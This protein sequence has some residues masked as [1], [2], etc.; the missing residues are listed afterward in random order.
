MIIAF[1]TIGFC[2]TISCYEIEFEENMFSV[3]NYVFV[4]G[5]ADV[6]ENINSDNYVDK[7]GLSAE[8]GNLNQKMLK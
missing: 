5:N 4:I 2:F 8:R 7:W 3:L 6:C 1:R